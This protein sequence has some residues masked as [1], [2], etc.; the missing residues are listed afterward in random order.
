MA[1]QLAT[2]L[3]PQISMLATFA[4]AQ[5]SANIR[6]LIEESTF[7]ELATCA[8]FC[9]AE[10]QICRLSALDQRVS[11]ESLID[12]VMDICNV[13]KSKAIALINAIHRL[14][15]K[16]YLMENLFDQGKTAADQWLNCQQEEKQPLKE[17]VDK[18]KNL[19]MFDMGIE[20]V[21]EQYNEQQQALYA[22]VDQSVGK[23]RR[24]TLFI[25]LSIACSTAAA[26]IYLLYW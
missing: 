15:K 21:N 26:L 24:R 1:T 3:E 22:S 7:L 4:Q 12:V 2:K 25:L 5:M 16:Y 9:G 19:T 23:L 13:S 14:E 20:G 17:L 6:Q 8:F 10:A 18:Y 11:L